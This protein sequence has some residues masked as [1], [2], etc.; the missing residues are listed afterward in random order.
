MCIFGGE[1]MC[2]HV[3]LSERCVP[4]S[5]IR[6]GPLLNIDGVIHLEGE[7]GAQSKWQQ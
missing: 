1:C 3:Y 4:V 7:E 2:T 5:L 6:A